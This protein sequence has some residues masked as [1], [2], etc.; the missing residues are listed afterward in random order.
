MGGYVLRRTLLAGL[1]LLVVTFIV[2]SVSRMIPGDAVALMCSERGYADD[3]DRLREEL[4]LSQPL[5]TQYLTWLGHIVR[6]DLGQSIWTKN[7]VLDEI[8]YRWPVTLE[9]G[10]LALLFSVSLAIPLGVISAVRQDSWLDYGL[11]TFAIGLLSMPTFW[12]AILAVVLAS[13]LFNYSSVRPFVPFAER[14]LQH[15]GQLLIPA[16]ALA[17]ATIGVTM[18]FTRAQMLEVLRQD[19][20]RTARAKGVPEWSVVGQHALRNALI[21]VITVIGSQLTF[22]VGGS[23]VIEQVFAIPGL[24][25]FMLAAISARDYPM[26]QGINLVL[27]GFVVVINL[28]IDIIYAVVDPRIRFR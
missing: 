18:R 26:V 6:L 24:G 20:V 9:L 5:L 23:V 1:T 13:V 21:P 27:A 10:I 14:P 12:K 17:G 8:A 19:Y 4:G 7:A 25:R 15:L 11:R 3:C 28:A 22:L 2:F 16:A